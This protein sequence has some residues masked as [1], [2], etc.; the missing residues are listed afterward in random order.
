MSYI[1][2]RFLT[3]GIV[4]TITALW[5]SASST[6]ASIS[7]TTSMAQLSSVLWKRGSF[8]QWWRSEVSFQ[9]TLSTVLRSRKAWCFAHFSQRLIVT[10]PDMCVCV[11]FVLRRNS[12]NTC[13]F[14]GF[15]FRC[16][17]ER[18]IYFYL[19]TPLN[20]EPVLFMF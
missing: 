10:F 11:M 9:A 12:L 15:N 6:T 14:V 8:T 16:Q 19:L 1:G 4:H 18:I 2:I 20:D 5:W 7:T 3:V 17:G 13:I